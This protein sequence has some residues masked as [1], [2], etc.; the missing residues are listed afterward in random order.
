ML[1]RSN[2]ADMGVHLTQCITE[3]VK[4]NIHALQSLDV[5]G[6]DVEGEKKA[7]GVAVSVHGHF[8]RMWA[9]LSLT[10]AVSMTHITVK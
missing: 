2:T 6:T 7:K 8:G 3:C 10:V 4:V 5:E 9:S 1:F